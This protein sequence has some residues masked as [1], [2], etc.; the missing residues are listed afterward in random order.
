MDGVAGWFEKRGEIPLAPPA[1]LREYAP[2]ADDPDRSEGGFAPDGVRGVACALEYCDSHGWVS[3]RLIRCLGI[4]VRTPATLRAYCHVRETTRTFRVDRIISIADFRSGAI[5]SGEAHLALLAPYLP[6]HDE[7]ARVV[8]M[9]AFQRATKDGVFALL[10]IAMPDGRLGE[11]PRGIVLD[12]VRA[13]A[14]AVDCPLP[15]AES[16][17]LWVDNLSPPL[18]GVVSAVGSLLAEKDKFARVLPWLLKI[19]RSQETFA[20][21]EDAIRDLIAEVRLHYRRKLMEFPS[22]FRATR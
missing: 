5:L 6:E 9:R 10:H 4:D 12:Y 17:E 11:K 2:L 13:E 15:A 7:D 20:I 1:R 3:T 22:H 14:A 18:D 19:V 8:A 21:Q 16:V